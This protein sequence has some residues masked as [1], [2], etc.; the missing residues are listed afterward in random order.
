MSDDYITIWRVSFDG[1]SF[2]CD[3][4][5]GKLSGGEV[6]TKERMKRSV[7]EALPEFG[8]F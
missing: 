6:A 1:A 5:P 4:D 7:Y 3:S 8:G 2:V